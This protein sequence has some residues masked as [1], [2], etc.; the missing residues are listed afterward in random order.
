MKNNNSEWFGVI[1]LA[2]LAIAMIFLAIFSKVG[3]RQEFTGTITKTYVDEGTTFFVIQKEGESQ[4]SAYANMDNWLA[5]KFNSGD[6]LVR[7]EVGKTYKFTSVG[8]RI[9]WLS[10]F[11]NLIRFENIDG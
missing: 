3:N 4:S 11:P 7:L 2:V 5:G 9:P 6:F 8:W 10:L 1:T